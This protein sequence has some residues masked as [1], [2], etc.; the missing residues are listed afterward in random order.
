M[1]G[2][3]PDDQS[4]GSRVHFVIWRWALWFAVLA[5]LME[6]MIV[7]VVRVASNRL[8]LISSD[9]VWTAP[10]ANAAVFSVASVIVW[11]VT[12]RLERSTAT[13]VALSVFLF[14]FL[15]GP[16]LIVP[17]LHQYAAVLLAAGVA[18]QGA[19]MVRR[20]IRWIDPLIRVT[21]PVFVLVSAALG[22][23]LHVS[24]SVLEKRAEAALPQAPPGSP[25]VLLIVLDTVR[26]QSLGMY[27]Y[28]RQTSPQLDKF[29]QSG[30][31]FERALS[32]APWTLPSHAS[33]FTGRLPHELRADWLT[34]LGKAHP[35]LAEALAAR[36]YVT[37]GFVANL[38]YATRETG[39]NRGFLHYSDFPLAPGWF[40][41]ESWL[42]RGLIRPLQNVVGDTDRLVGK[43]A[44]EV[45]EE[46]LKWL[47]TRPQRPFFAFLNY[48]DAHAPYLPPSP[49]DVKFGNGGP[50]ADITVRRYWSQEQIQRSNDAYDGTIAY[51]DQQVGALLTTLKTQGV[52][53]NTLVVVTSDHGEQFGEHGLFDHGNGLYRP[54]L[55]VPLVISFPT[56]VPAGIRVSQPVSLIDL[57]ATIMDLT[58]ATNGDSVFPGE[59][60]SDYWHSPLL[61]QKQRPLVAEVSKA[62][63]MPDWLPATKGNMQSVIVGGMHFIRNGDGTEELYDFEHDVAE[64][65]NLA[66]LTEFH[67]ALEE[68]R[69]ALKRP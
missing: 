46:F 57:G 13:S 16:I 55:H 14:L 36:G 64:A 44:P 29:S 4:S 42:T 21:L 25:N 19:Q 40:V 5:G 6:A 1:T 69:R 17:G 18:V 3:T 68:A 59:T 26:A 56:H 32:T 63:N 33:L 35:T 41:R 15:L 7:G 31:V 51:L 12:R 9:V 58:N 48:F 8:V 62:I 50:Q 11:L 66:G 23:G 38:L 43:R 53:E 49:F 22:A 10:I 45:N 60:L 47:A 61:N 67:A 30:V 54:V 37:A 52:L 39:L 24:R 65:H 20:R 27:G 28:Q 2:L 34:P